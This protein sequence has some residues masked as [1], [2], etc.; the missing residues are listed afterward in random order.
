[1]FRAFN[2][3]AGFYADLI[4]LADEGGSTVGAEFNASPAETGALLQKRMDRGNLVG[5]RLA[6]AESRERLLEAIG[7]LERRYKDLTKPEAY[8]VRLTR[9]LNAL[10]INERLRADQRQS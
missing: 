10:V 4:G 2:S 5:T 6:L 8:P 3:R 9:A 7:R 1:V